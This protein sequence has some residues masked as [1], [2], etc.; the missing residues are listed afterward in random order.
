MSLAKATQ[1]P[2]A[3]H[4]AA[5]LTQEIEEVKEKE[6]SEDLKK[7]T[8]A[9]EKEPTVYDYLAS[10]GGPTE[11]TVLEW[12]AAHGDVHLLPLDDD[13][14]AIFRSVKRSEWQQLTAMFARAGENLSEAAQEEQLVQKCLLYPKLDPRMTAF[15]RA[16]FI[17]TV[18]SAILKCSHFLDEHTIMKMVIKL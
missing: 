1:S 8:E 14:I 12:K 5:P 16:G 9:V 4:Q 13:T 6:V 2:M 11:E 15:T 18:A 7:Q 17:G 10:I 3:A